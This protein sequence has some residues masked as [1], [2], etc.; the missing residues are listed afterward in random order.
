MSD[1]R[2]FDLAHRLQFQLDPAFMAL[3]AD[4]LA[5]LL[6]EAEPC[7]LELV[8]CLQGEALEFGIDL[9]REARLHLINARKC[10]GMAE[11]RI[12]LFGFDIGPARNRI[13]L[14]QM[15]D[16]DKAPAITTRERMAPRFHR[17]RKRLP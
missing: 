5:L 1:A 16:G 6:V 11:P 4:Q 13:D 9:L 12:D 10:L 8:S 15:V 2:L 17:L 14:S 3:P 7:L